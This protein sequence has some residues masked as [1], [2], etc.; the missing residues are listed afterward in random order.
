M[1]T[2][3]PLSSL[4]FCQPEAFRKWWCPGNCSDPSSTF[5]C[6]LCWNNS[7]WH[8]ILCLYHLASLLDHQTRGD[9]RPG[10]GTIANCISAITVELTKF[11]HAVT[12]L[13]IIGAGKFKAIILFSPAYD[14]Y[15]DLK[16]A[17]INTI[18]KLKLLKTWSSF[19]CQFL[20]IENHPDFSATWGSL[21]AD[22]MT[23][24]CAS[25]LPSCPWKHMISSLGHQELTSTI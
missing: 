14:K 21:N 25:L 18:G 8:N 1:G 19:P 12:N 6:C 13:V 3:Y 23:L 5:P 20:S 16:A 4:A 11:N 2:F 7:T 17:L 10:G 24:F 15:D 9:V 22:P